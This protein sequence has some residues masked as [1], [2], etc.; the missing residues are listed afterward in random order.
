MLLLLRCH[1]NFESIHSQQSEKF[2]SLADKERIANCSIGN[3]YFLSDMT[4]LSQAIRNKR[5]RQAR[6]LIEA[7]SDINW[8]GQNKR[9]V[10]MEVCFLDDEEKA[11]GLAKMLLKNGADLNFQ[12]EQGLITLSYACI[13]KRKKLVALFLQYVDYDLNAVDRDGNTALFHAITVGDIS[14]VKM[15]VKK[16]KYY[17]LSVDTQNSKGETPLIHAL[18]VGHAQ[19]ADILIEDGKASLEVCDLEHYKTAAQWKKE[20][21][22]KRKRIISPFYTV[23][24][25]KVTEKSTQKLR[26]TVSAKAMKGCLFPDIVERKKMKKD[27]PLTAPDRIIVPAFFTPCTPVQEDLLRLYGIFNQQTTSSYRKGYKFVP[28]PVKPLPPL[29]EEGTEGIEENPSE[30]GKSKM[31]FSQINEI[32]VRLKG[33]QKA[34]KNRKNSSSPLSNTNTAGSPLNSEG[35]VKSGKKK[36]AKLVRKGESTESPGIEISLEAEKN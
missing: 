22:R 33:L 14:I 15:I 26:K 2:D 20:M 10:I 19:C 11:L 27:R 8:K 16:L 7:G 25:K 6:L 28:K 5:W 18:K 31:N 17:A 34:V 30:Q 13:L 4:A 21:Q 23:E 24:N 32:N 1:C 9:S 3:S 29:A 36:T 12:D 35:R